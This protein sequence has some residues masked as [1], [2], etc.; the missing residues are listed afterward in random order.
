MAMPISETPILLVKDA[1]V[2]SKKIKENETEKAP[3]E[4]FDRAMTNYKKIKGICKK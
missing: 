3:K 2:F 4:E 1:E